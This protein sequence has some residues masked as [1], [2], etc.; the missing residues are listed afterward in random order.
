MESGPKVPQGPNIEIL[1]PAAERITERSAAKVLQ[2][3][4]AQFSSSNTQEREKALSKLVAFIK[5]DTDKKLMEKLVDKEFQP[6]LEDA[7]RKTL[8]VEFE[9]HGQDP[10]KKVWQDG[11]TVVALSEDGKVMGATS[12]PG[13]VWKVYGD[14]NKYALIKA[15]AE[16]HL[17]KANRFGGLSKPDNFK[18]LVGLGL[19]PPSKNEPDPDLFTGSTEGVAVGDSI[20]YVGGSGCAADREYLKELLAM[21]KE[22]ELAIDTQAGLFDSVFSRLTA[23]YM[24]NPNLPQTR[25]EPN[26]IQQLQIQN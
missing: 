8:A 18:Y 21:F 20:I 14:L 6:K 5:A 19:K 16:L 3:R 24:R 2:E 11:Y 1:D 22:G 4:L 26:S 9:R 25:Q 23:S 10:V 15:L 17:Y 13:E 12:V 7:T